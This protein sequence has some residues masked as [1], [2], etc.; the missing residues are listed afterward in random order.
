M[1][2]QAF[3]EALAEAEKMEVVPFT[4]IAERL[5]YCDQARVSPPEWRERI[6]A[7]QAAVA[8]RMPG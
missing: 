6:A 3:A 7:R 1:L 2:T 4:R 5:P 8:E